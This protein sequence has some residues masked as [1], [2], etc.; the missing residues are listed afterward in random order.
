[1]TDN[2]ATAVEPHE[3]RLTSDEPLRSGSLTKTI[4]AWIKRHD[5]NYAALRSRAARTAIIMPILFALSIYV[6]DNVDVATFVAF[7]SIAL[8]LFV[9]FSGPMRSRLQAQA[10]LSVTGGVFVCLGTLTSRTIWLSVL[11][12]GVVTLVVI[13]A[14]VVSSVLASATTSLLLTFILS[15]AVSGPNFVIPARLIGW[16]IASVVAFFAVWLL[17]S[18]KGQSALRV[19]ASSACQAIAAKLQADVLMW[20]GTEAYSSDQYREIVSAAHAAVDTLHHGFLAAPLRPTGLSISSRAIVRLVDELLWLDAQLIE[21]PQSVDATSMTPQALR[22][23]SSSADVLGA[24]ANLLNSPFTL[25]TKLD[26]ALDDLRTTL[27]DMERE[28]TVHFPVVSK[29]ESNANDPKIDGRSGRIEERVDS[30]ETSFR[31]QELGFTAS[32]IGDNISLAAAADRRGWLD[33]IAG[34]VPGTPSGRLASARRRAG[35]H[36][37]LHSVWLH[38]SIRGAIGFAVA[39]FIAEK[40]GLQHSFWVILGTLSMA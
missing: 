19:A 30:L 28:T 6:I 38:N 15:T 18:S 8:L 1:V 25:S 7:G 40:T 17:W 20:R 14:G 10:A 16:G 23:F 32:L 2:G 22:I 35:A 36:F 29:S 5:Q 11:S 9:D 31:V 37:E 12:M 4:I 24:G 27:K 3:P 21:L 13:F 39:V 34:R 33:A 26:D